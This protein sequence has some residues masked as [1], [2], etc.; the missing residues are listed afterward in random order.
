MS[1]P[2][3]KKLIEYADESGVKIIINGFNYKPSL[4]AWLGGV[5]TLA[6]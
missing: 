5:S 4:S 3:T 6:Q 1:V 2:F